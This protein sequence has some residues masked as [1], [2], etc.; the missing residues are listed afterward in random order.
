M[1]WSKE[2]TETSESAIWHILQNLFVKQLTFVYSSGFPSGQPQ[3]P[4]THFVGLNNFFKNSDSFEFGYHLILKWIWS[5]VFGVNE[6]EI[7]LKP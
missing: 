1:L 4:V 3:C 5:R 2:W 7:A 6:M